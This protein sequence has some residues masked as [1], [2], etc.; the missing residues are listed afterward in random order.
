VVG[1]ERRQKI[2][3]ICV[4]DAGSRRGRNLERVC[5]QTWTSAKWWEMGELMLYY[6]GRLEL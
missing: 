4:V 5:L 6:Y 3:E 2:F 1:E